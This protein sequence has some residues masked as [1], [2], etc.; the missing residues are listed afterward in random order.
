VIL[1]L[2][3]GACAGV[4][5]GRGWPE[6]LWEQLHGSQVVANAG[7]PGAR[8]V[9]VVRLLPTWPGPVPAVVVLQVGTED[10]RGGGMPPSEFCGLLQQAVDT[11]RSLWPCAVL[12]VCTAPPLVPTSVSG[13]NRAA[14]RWL[15]RVE[16]L[17]I[18][19]AASNGV[20]LAGLGSMPEEL[21]A[22]GV[23]PSREGARWI[24]ALVAAVIP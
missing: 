20:L 22:D 7:A 5:A 10:A 1:C 3:G 23:H 14:R 6:H 24:A 15:R 11:A 4:R 17:V 16:P 9:D 12:V 19:L 2:G 13:Y 18:A 21:L 8:L